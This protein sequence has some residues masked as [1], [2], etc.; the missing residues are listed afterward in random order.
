MGAISRREKQR[1]QGEYFIDGQSQ[2]KQQIQRYYYYY[3][4]EFK[5]E[6]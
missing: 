2:L 5:V 4:F 1:Y 6:K 3:L